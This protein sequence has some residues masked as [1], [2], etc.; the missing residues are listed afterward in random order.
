LQQLNE[1]AVPGHNRDERL[2]I[3]L[4]PDELRAIDDFRYRHRIPT[5]AASVRELMKRGLEGA[6]TGA[7]HEGSRSKDFGVL[8]TRNGTGFD[9]DEP[10]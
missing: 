10:V 1:A 2:Q 4:S 7:S 6:K 5:R 9:P 8:E 3:M